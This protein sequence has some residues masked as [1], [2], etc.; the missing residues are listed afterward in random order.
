MGWLLGA[1]VPFLPVGFLAGRCLRRARLA[2]GLAGMF[3]PVVVWPLIGVGLREGWWGNSTE[4]ESL[5]QGIVLLALVSVLSA[6]T[7]AMIGFL[8]ARRPAT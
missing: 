6:G 8:L 1:I 7:S 2:C 3:L 5:T 4:A